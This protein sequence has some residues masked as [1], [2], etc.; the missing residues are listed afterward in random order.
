MKSYPHV[1]NKLF[2]EPLLVTHERHAAMVRVLEARLGSGMPADFEGPEP[3]DPEDLRLDWQP[4]PVT[5]IPVHGVL[6][7][8]A[9]D[10]P[11][12]SCGCGLDEV[13]LRIEEVLADDSVKRIIFDFRSPGGAYTGTPELGR[14]IAGITSKKTIAFTDDQCCS[15][16]L[17]LA[18]QCQSFFATSSAVVGSIGVWCAYLD[19]SRQMAN[20]GENLQE[21]SA[22]KYKTMGAYWKALT[23]EEKGM[24]QKQVDKI[25]LEF[26]LAVTSRREVAEEFMQGQV[27]DGE[28]AVA[29]GI[30]D[31]LVESIDEVLDQ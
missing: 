13:R 17:W 6:V 22:G 18:M 26:K 7:G 4:G 3:E 16:A 23:P 2:Y 19:L 20:G 10:I 8:H 15:G 5:I 25:Y 24:I 28:E 27:F 9:S 11:M 1:I 29:A 31:G 14:K 21:I 30:C 12:S